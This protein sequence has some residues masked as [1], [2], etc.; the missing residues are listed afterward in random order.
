[1]FINLKFPHIPQQDLSV[2]A[3]FI[4]YKH[5]DGT[6]FLALYIEAFPNQLLLCLCH[7]FT[8][9]EN[10]RSSVYTRFKSLHKN[11]QWREVW[12]SWKPQPWF[13]FSGLSVRKYDVRTFHTSRMKWG[14]AL[15]CLNKISSCISSSMLST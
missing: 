3:L 5:L 1:M 11:I 8:N 14:V 10:L 9:D 13:A 6:Q 7:F 4:A 2:C 12:I 15:S